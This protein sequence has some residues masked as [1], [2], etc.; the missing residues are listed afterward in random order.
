MTWND[1]IPSHTPVLAGA[2]FFTVEVLT[3][4]RLRRIT[5]FLHSARDLTCD[6]GRRNAASHTEEWMEQMA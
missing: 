6:A 1:F 3:L 2:D 4:R 5:F